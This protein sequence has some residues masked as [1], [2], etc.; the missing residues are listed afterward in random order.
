M[1]INRKMIRFMKFWHFFIFATILYACATLNRTHSP[2]ELE[3]TLDNALIEI[4]IIYLKNGNSISLGGYFKDAKSEFDKISSENQIPLVIYLHGCGGIG[5]NSLRDMEFLVNNNYAVILPDSFARN[6]RPK[7]CNPSTKKGGF[8]RGVLK[9]RLAEARYAHE[10]AKALPWVNKQKIFMMGHSEGGI[11][12]AKYDHGGLA[13][14]IIMGWS[15]HAGW[16]EYAGISGLGNEPIISFV[17]SKE[18]WLTGEHRSGDCGSFMGKRP[19]TESVIVDVSIP[20]HWVGYDPEVK[21][22]I[23]QFLKANS[24]P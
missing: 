8:F 23:L 20:T 1:R 13:G 22:K 16:A 14:R 9:M 10:A 3:R 2:E 18:S 4:P 17:A 5:I 15:C 19:N 12:T 24:E 21:K 11:T 7:G 6:F